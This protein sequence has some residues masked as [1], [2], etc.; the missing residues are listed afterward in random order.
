MN[1]EQTQPTNDAPT[2]CRQQNSLRETAPAETK[3]MRSQYNRAC[4]ALLFVCA[5][6]AAS[7]LVMTFRCRTA[8][9]GFLTLRA[10]VFDNLYRSFKG[11]T[12]TAA[13]LTAAFFSLGKRRFDKTL[14]CKPAFLIL[15]GCL[16]AIWLMAEGF[17]IDNTL[18]HLSMT[19]GQ[20]VKCVVY[21][22]GIFYLFYELIAWF[23]RF[24][25]NTSHMPAALNAQTVRSE[26]KLSAAQTVRQ[27][28]IQYRFWIITVILL[29]IWYGPVFT[30]YPAIV[31]NDAWTQLSQYWGLTPFTA[32]HP[33]F[34][35]VLIGLFSRIGLLFGNA[36]A[37]LFAYILIQTILY[38]L[39]IA[40]SCELLAKLKAPSWLWTVYLAAVIL[41]PYFSNRVGNISKDNLF[42]VSVLLFIT[43]LIH[44]LLDP[45]RFTQ[46]RKHFVLSIV[47]IDGTLLLRN[48]GKHI[49]YPTMLVIAL[50]LFQKR[51]TLH[52][53]VIKKGASILLIGLI[54]SFLITAVLR[55]IYHIEDGSIAEAL[56]LPFQQTSRTVL[57]HGEEITDEERDAIDAVLPYDQLAELYRP[58]ISDPVKAQMRQEA[59]TSDLIHYLIVWLRMFPKYPDSYFCASINQS[60]GLVYLPREGNRVYMDFYGSESQNEIVDAMQNEIG[61]E[62]DEEAKAAER[63]MY[64]K[65][66][67][68]MFSAPV[69]GILCHPAL[70]VL[71]IMITSIFAVGKKLYRYLIPALP[72]LLSIVVIIL[73][74]TFLRHPRYAFPIV[75]SVPVILAYYIALNRG[76]DAGAPLSDRE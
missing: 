9:T 8:E 19:T 74:P 40:Y 62:Q 26:G 45:E 22:I 10:E 52:R 49:L 41:S 37:G 65:W 6:F 13:I 14:I 44:A 25:E 5:L 71:V 32:H 12:V 70:Y 23:F 31:G 73:A 47:A 18:D 60:Y 55:G 53:E 2:A 68:F 48:N 67:Y 4:K 56:S 66:Y 27:Y 51:N 36:N 24:L 1:T 75:Y 3:R 7:A 58:M 33:P 29:V 46:N 59:T 64:K 38:A 35:T 30:A 42:S 16:A 61:L 21:Y 69:V 11:K 17:R 15:S 72:M 20:T 34:H 50:L 39:T 54:S 43:E 63:E 57:E 76:A 28:V